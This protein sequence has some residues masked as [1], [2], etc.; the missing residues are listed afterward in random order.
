MKDNRSIHER[1]AAFHDTWAKGTDLKSIRVIEA[2]EAP[3]AVENQF[4]IRE[5]GSLVGKK[6]LDVG[7]GLG[8]SSVYFALKGAQVTTT[9]ISPGMVKTAVRLGE[10]H[11][12]KLDGVVST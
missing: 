4:I 5:M 12:V 3:T 1:E 10:L 7:A 11:G 8:E 6:V 2:M 9:D